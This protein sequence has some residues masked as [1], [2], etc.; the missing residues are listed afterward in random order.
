M[1]NIECRVK[2]FNHKEE[3]INRKKCVFPGGQE[4]IMV[5][6]ENTALHQI[7]A[8]RDLEIKELIYI[9]PICGKEFK[10]RHGLVT[11]IFKTHPEESYK[12]KGKK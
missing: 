1:L 6:R 3:R 5:V 12:L 2:V 11:H 10:K 8:C 9:C 4:R 7:K